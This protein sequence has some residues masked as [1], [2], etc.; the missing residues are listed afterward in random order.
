MEIAL[1][2]VVLEQLIYLMDMILGLKK[3]QQSQLKR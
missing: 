3:T 2:I 1:Y